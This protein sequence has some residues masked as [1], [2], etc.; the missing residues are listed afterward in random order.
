MLTAF[1]VLRTFSSNPEKRIRQYKHLRDVWCLQGYVVMVAMLGTCTVS[2]YGSKTF[3]KVAFETLSGLI[4]CGSVV[5]LRRAI[6]ATRKVGRVY[7]LGRI[8]YNSGIFPL[9]CT[10]VMNQSSMIILDLIMIGEPY[11]PYANAKWW[12]IGNGTAD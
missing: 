12:S 11:I 8:L 5:V 1:G 3:R 6:T 2:D 7:R 10:H 9:K 4:S